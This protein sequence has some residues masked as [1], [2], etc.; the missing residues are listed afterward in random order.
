MISP[1]VASSPL[2]P[3]HVRALNNRLARR[4]QSDVS[5][6]RSFHEC[7]AQGMTADECQAYIEDLLGGPDLPNHEIPDLQ[8]QI[9]RPRP[10]NWREDTYWMIGIPT[11]IYGEV[12]CGLNGAVIRYPWA[13]TVAGVDYNIPDVPCIGLN[14]LDCCHE[15]MET[16]SAAGIPLTNEQGNC[17]S[18]WVHQE[19]LE[20]IIPEGASE[21]H[22]LEHVAVHG[23]CTEILLSISEVDAEDAAV[24]EALAVISNDIDSIVSSDSV[25][26]SIFAGLF[27]DLLVNARGLPRAMSRI[28]S[29]LCGIF[30]NDAC[31]S[32]NLNVDITQDII[33]RLMWIKKE[34]SR[35]LNSAQNNIVIYVDHQGKVMEPPKIGGSREGLDWDRDDPDYDDRV[36]SNLTIS[37][38]C[39]GLSGPGD[40]SISPVYSSQPGSD[41]N[42]TI[43]LDESSSMIS[44]AHS[45]DITSP[46]I[47]P[48]VTDYN[49]NDTAVDFSSNRSFGSASCEGGK[50]PDES[51]NCVCPLDKIQDESG[52]CNWDKSLCTEKTLELS[53]GYCACY[54]SHIRTANNECVSTDNPKC[55]GFLVEHPERGCVCP[56]GLACYCP[57]GFILN[58]NQECV[59]DHSRDEPLG[60]GVPPIES[61]LSQS[62]GIVTCQD[63]KLKDS[64]DNCVCPQGKVESEKGDCVWDKLLCT[65]KTL[66]L[67]D[68]YCAC[69]PSHIRTENNECVSTDTPKCFGFLVEHPGKGCVCPPGLAC[70][71]PD[72]F[73]LNENQECVQEY[74]NSQPSHSTV[75]SVRS[76]HESLIKHIHEDQPCTGNKMQ[77]P[78][79]YCVCFPGHVRN[80]NGECEPTDSPNCPGLLVEHPD[81]GCLC[82]PG[83]TCECPLGFVLDNKQEC[84]LLCE[85]NLIEKNRK[86][87]CPQ[88]SAKDENGICRV[89]DSDRVEIEG[90]CVCR[91]GIVSLP[92]G[93][94][95][96]PEG[97]VRGPTSCFSCPPPSKPDALTGECVCPPGMGISGDTCVCTEPGKFMSQNGLECVEPSSACPPGTHYIPEKGD[98]VSCNCGFCPRRDQTDREDSGCC[99]F[100]SQS[101]KCEPVHSNLNSPGCFFSNTEIFYPSYSDQIGNVCSATESKK[102]MCS[103]KL[104]ASTPCIFEPAVEESCFFCSVEDLSDR[105]SGPSDVCSGCREC[106]KSNCQSSWSEGECQM[107]LDRT[108]HGSASQWSTCLGNAV[109]QRFHGLRSFSSRNLPISDGECSLSCR[110]YC[111]HGVS[112]P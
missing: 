104:S 75:R 72:G 77:L 37:E 61:T 81:K 84:I 99:F 80:E 95:G 42:S 83:L 39:V 64:Q 101:N 47:V 90:E 91:K 23:T 41:A 31:L 25:S 112:F 18:C 49:S 86:C 17:L 29:L 5:T 76:I 105:S 6:L 1:Y 58:E 2:G 8:I 53:D 32:Y 62:N 36:A 3:Q 71:C 50:V 11:N 88:G 27:Q 110:E 87:V 4:M 60:F 65:E 74:Y 89:C 98:C 7:V 19:N 92:D 44:P 48:N 30:P 15:V 13:W 35:E 26:C 82:P 56:P 59:Q 97:Q 20:P 55:F 40:A 78:D 68:G 28:S 107:L 51:G 73:V 108:H 69:Y 45:G 96:C 57:D 93:S 109:V 16:I 111:F 10:A 52:E 63:E 66:E 46:M 54:P 34:I 12:D 67:A 85:N 33:N 9:S 102:G 103:C 14:A 43:G 22:Y 100:N 94:C 38:D 24:S 106:L 21:V 70:D 79:G